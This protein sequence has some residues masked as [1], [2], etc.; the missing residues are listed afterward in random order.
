MKKTLFAL[1]A[2]CLALVFGCCGEMQTAKAATNGDWDYEYVGSGIRIT[3]YNGKD[4]DVVIPGTFGGSLPSWAMPYSA[5]IRTSRAST[6][7]KRPV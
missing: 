5:I 6:S 3:K 7:L 4:T 2:L 1:M